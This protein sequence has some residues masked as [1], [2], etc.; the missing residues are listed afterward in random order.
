MHIVL[1]TT[2]AI[3]VIGGSGTAVYYNALVGGLRS[4][5]Y[6]V[7]VIA[8]NFD[9]SDYVQITLQRLLFNT[10][11]RTDPHINNADLIIGLD[12]DGYGLNPATR[13]PML[14]SALAVYGDVIQWESEPFRTMVES[15]AFFDRVAMHRTDHITIG[16]EYAK[17]RIVSLYGI[18]P[19]KITAI[20]LGME[21]PNWLNFYDSEPHQPND[22]PVLLAVGKLF[23]R[24]RI[25]VLL[26]ALVLLRQDF[27][28]IELRIIGN[29]LE[30][31]RLHSLADE[32]AIT[33]NVTWLSHID[34]DAAFAREWRQADIFCHPS[35]QETFGYVYLEAMTV[36][37]AIVAADAGAAPEVLDGAG[38]LV[39]PG[40]PQAFADGIKRFLLDPGLR[41]HYSTLARQRA[42]LY[43]LDRMIDSYVTI[44]EHLA[45]KSPRKP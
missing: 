19:D 22:H 20:P 36:G 6:T 15:Q 23:P 41:A 18:S 10:D 8:P 45:A 17:Q 44:I 31:D 34:D 5:G 2:W 24:K 30:W 42:P 29:G 27:P 9:T 35:N 25:D 43:T 12:Y 13:P 39:A 7:E 32:L 11:L 16:S 38:L 21:P 37:K 28:T 14:T 26:R 4:R 3:D 1:I 40:D 33:S